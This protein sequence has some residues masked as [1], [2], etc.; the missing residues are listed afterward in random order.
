MTHHV[1]NENDIDI[2]VPG[3]GRWQK[4]K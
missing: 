2:A 3:S 1:F 4:D